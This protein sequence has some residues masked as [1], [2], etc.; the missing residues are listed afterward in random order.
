MFIEYRTVPL[1]AFTQ[2]SVNESE[3]ATTSESSSTMS[4]SKR[5]RLGRSDSS[6]VLYFRVSRRESVPARRPPA[7]RNKAAT[8]IVA[9]DRTMT[10]VRS[11]PPAAFY[12]YT[13]PKPDRKD[14]PAIVIRCGLRAE[15]LKIGDNLVGF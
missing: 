15:S 4:R 13:W 12:R 7:E 2:Q 1:R 5:S 6:F 9:S 14:E 11:I 3:T 10:K 8:A